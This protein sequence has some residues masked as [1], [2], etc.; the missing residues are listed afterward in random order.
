MRSRR[1]VGPAFSQILS[2]TASIGP[3]ASARIEH[4]D[5]RRHPI[6]DAEIVPERPVHTRHYCSAVL[7]KACASQDAQSAHP[8]RDR[9]A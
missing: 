7:P 6:A 5:V 4:V 9:K 1:C 2:V 3:G 8:D